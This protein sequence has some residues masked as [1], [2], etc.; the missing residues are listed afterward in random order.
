MTVPIELRPVIATCLFQS[1]PVFGMETLM[2]LNQFICPTGFPLFPWSYDNRSALTIRIAVEAETPR[3]QVA[4]SPMVPISRRG[5][6]LLLIKASSIRFNARESRFRFPGYPCARY[7]YP[8]LDPNSFSRHLF[9]ISSFHFPL[10]APE[11][12]LCQ[13]RRPNPL[14]QHT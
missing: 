5:I 2:L 14:I 4:V 10:P 1:T 9:E 7:Q 12:S 13:L 3:S 6:C 11:A 8:E